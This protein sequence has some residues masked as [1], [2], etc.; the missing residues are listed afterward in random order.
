MGVIFSK[1]SFLLIY[2]T[3]IIIRILVYSLSLESTS[4]S[5]NFGFIEISDFNAFL[6]EHFNVFSTFFHKQFLSLYYFI[7]FV[8]VLLIETICL[9][10][11]AR[12]AVLKNIYKLLFIF[13]L[14]PLSVLFYYYL[15][16]SPLL[17]LFFL[18]FFYFY[19][20]RNYFTSSL[21]LGTLVIF[22]NLF[23]LL[24]PILILHHFQKKWFKSTR[25]KFLLSLVFF[26]S[27]ALVFKNIFG[28]QNV[29]LGGKYF[30]GDILFT[31]L[32]LSLLFFIR[33]IGRSNYAMLNTYVCLLFLLHTLIF[34]NYISNIQLLI[35]I[36][37]IYVLNSTLA[38]LKITFIYFTFYL[39]YL[40]HN[41]N[42]IQFNTFSNLDSEYILLLVL[43]TFSFTLIFRLLTE[44]VQYNPY[45]RVN[46]WPLTI[47]IAGDSG[48]GKDTLAKSVAH[49]FHRECVTTLYG[50]SY[51]KWERGAPMWKAFTHL[52]PTA[53]DLDSLNDNLTSLLRG[54]TL[55]IRH[56]NHRIGRFVAPTPVE[57]NDVIIVSGLHALFQPN[58]RALIDLK[59]FL[60]TDERL[61]KF[62]KLSRDSSS[63]MQ[64]LEKISRIIELRKSDAE[65]YI[66]PQAAFADI[67]FRLS[68]VNNDL[69]EGDTFSENLRFTLSVILR[70]SNYH[71][72]LIKILI[73]YC[74]LYLDW[75]IS[76][77]GRTVEI[78]IDGDVSSEDISLAANFLMP[79][80]D[81][82]IDVNFNWKNDL[83][84]VIQLI[85]FSHINQI[86]EK[87]IL[88]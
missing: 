57:P 12:H 14:S 41:F 76:E 53:N 75:E 73:G 10:L 48:S 6:F 45:Y 72:D 67:V 80:L 9:L 2:I 68:P 55:H 11:L 38:G 77:D 42:I 25:I 35:P 87:R 15:N 26:V 54:E 30:I 86:L 29:Y 74:G 5:T 61:R 83:E 46:R 44:G 19:S 27:L 49:I 47:S 16:L 18:L 65:K 50:D 84:G 58:F 24:I 60:D 56:Y 82:Y 62:W 28:I 32:Y 69:F 34:P 20:N 88:K 22:Q 21:L 81:K 17:F 37:S 39:I 4:N 71:Q 7:N 70:D 3:G 36:I 13:W 78:I 79:D 23:L 66:R 59:I 40:C 51:H 43:I 52:N 85:I 63:R 31:I 33:R 1:K 8:F 64:S